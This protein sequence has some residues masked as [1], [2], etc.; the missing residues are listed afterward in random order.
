MPPGT[1]DD[2]NETVN[3]RRTRR[4][5]IG[6]GAVAIAM[7]SVSIA[8]N[9]AAFSHRLDPAQAQA[10]WAALGLGAAAALI[11]VWLLA[12]PRQ[13]GQP[14]ALTQNRGCRGFV[15]FLVALWTVMLA[16]SATLEQPQVMTGVPSLGAAGALLLLFVPPG[17]GDAVVGR[18]LTSGQRRL[19]RMF[20][21]MCFALGLGVLGAAAVAASTAGTLLPLGVLVPPGICLL[22]LAGAVRRRVRAEED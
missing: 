9:A 21:I 2:V 7:G 10:A 19:W 6:A 4:A 15:V 3:R 8:L 13:R 11:G 20:M 1:G 16:A 5:R 17:S 22:V 18:A 12:G 14:V